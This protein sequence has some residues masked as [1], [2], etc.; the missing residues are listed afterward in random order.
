LGTSSDGLNQP[1]AVRRL[2]QFGYNEVFE[3]EINP[4]SPGRVMIGILA[5][6][7]GRPESTAGGPFHL[8]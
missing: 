3:K 7:S 4:L 2:Q 1:E 8:A 6:G 5:A